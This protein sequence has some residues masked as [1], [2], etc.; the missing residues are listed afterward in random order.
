MKTLRKRKP[1]AYILLGEISLVRLAFVAAMLSI[2]AIEWSRR[3]GR[4]KTRKRRHTVL[5]T[6]NIRKEG[7]GVRWSIIIDC[8]QNKQC[9]GE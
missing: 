9:V 3:K 7:G 6:L 5:H 4:I 1:R 2:I 8:R